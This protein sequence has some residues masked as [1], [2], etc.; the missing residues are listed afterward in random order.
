M[1]K[2]RKD[3]GIVKVPV[4]NK[5]KNE[6][7]KHSISLTEEQY[8]QFS[9]YLESNNKTKRSD[10]NLFC[11]SFLI[12]YATYNTITD[13]QATIE[14]YIKSNSLGYSVTEEKL[15]LKYG[16]IEGEKRWLDKKAKSG[17][18]KEKM[19]IKYGEELGIEK[20]N[21]YC[22]K[23]AETNSFEYKAKKY[24]MTEDEFKEYNKSRAVTKDNLIKRHGEEEGLKKWN[25]YCERQSY[26]GCKLEY[27]I[28]KYGEEE[29]TKFYN[30]L[31]KTKVQ[32]YENYVMR[33][34]VEEGRIKWE[35]YL[36]HNRNLYSKISQELFTKLYNGLKLT[37][38]DCFYATLNYEKF[39][40]TLPKSYKYDFC[41]ESKKIIIEFNGN[42]YHANPK[43]YK[44]DDIIS[45]RYKKCSA[46][47]I[48]EYDYQ[49]NKF[50]E[51]AG[52]KVI[53]VWESDYK[54]NKE[55][56]INELIEAINNE[57]TK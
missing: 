32:S 14:R 39:L 36:K 57:S 40:Y 20:W 37:N 18:T 34:G 42:L 25:D 6:C 38:D 9:N 27:F 2:Q 31:N 15:K 22:K 28:E 35:N 12:P 51:D 54:E 16:D 43:I 29:G 8:I 10:V 33:W 1:H 44:K 46:E 24:G 13:I 11:S 26:A 55:K 4:I 50:A 47:E 53:V 30:E 19:I 3:T 21:S 17:Q 48:W 23:Q 49:K 7:G 52:Y 5:L 56:V 45:I 41:I